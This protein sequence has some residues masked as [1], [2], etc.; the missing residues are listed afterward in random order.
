MDKEFKLAIRFED[1]DGLDTLYSA[2][3]VSDVSDVPN[4][5]P[6]CV[7]YQLPKADFTQYLLEHLGLSE[8]SE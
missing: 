6:K 5:E 8:D 1:L 2:W 7:A 3:D 4:A